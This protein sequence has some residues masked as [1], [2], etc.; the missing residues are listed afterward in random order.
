[1]DYDKLYEELKQKDYDE[2][3]AG[4]TQA[5]EQARDKKLAQQMVVA[6]LTIPYMFALQNPYIDELL[7]L[8]ELNWKLGISFNHVAE[9]IPDL[10]KK[11]FAAMKY[12]ASTGANKSEI[13][14]VKI[15]G[16]KVH[17]THTLSLD[18]SYVEGHAETGQF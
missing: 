1:M 9:Q 8:F 17:T 7:K 15:Q 4:Y 11:H 2:I 3:L 16:D 12:M 6:Q 10:R 5:Y 14:D 13:T 18:G